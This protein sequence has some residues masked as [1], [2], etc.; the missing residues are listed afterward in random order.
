MCT[1]HD[2]YLMDGDPVVAVVAGWPPCPLARGIPTL[3]ACL[4]PAPRA[5]ATPPPHC[6]A[7]SNY[8]HLHR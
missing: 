2:G 8:F 6:M 7:A 1:F 4:D 3:A 5:G